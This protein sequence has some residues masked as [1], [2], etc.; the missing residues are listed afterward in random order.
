MSRSAQTGDNSLATTC[1]ARQPIV[2][3]AGRLAAYELLFR[4]G[5]S[6]VAN[7]SDGFRCTAEVVERTLGALGLTTVLDGLDGYLNCTADFLHSALPQM[8]PSQHF[9]LEV[10]ETCELD[11]ALK[12]RCIALRRAGFRVAIDDVVAI[13][14]QIEAFLPAVDIVKLE[15]PALDAA[16]AKA[17]VRDMKRAG[18]TVVAEKVDDHQQLQAALDAGCDLVQGFY[19]SRPQLL[20]ARR[21]VPDV[22]QL[23]AVLN[24]LI[25]DA[26]D[27]RIVNALSG[28]PVLVAQLMRLA[29]CSASANVKQAAIT[30]LHHALAVTG[31]TRLFEWCSLLLY[32][33]P[34]SGDLSRD[35][36]IAL[37]TQR[38]SFMMQAALRQRPSETAFAQT[39]S[40]TGMLSLL[41]VIYGREQAQFAQELPLAQN[42][43]DALADRR[44]ELGQLL[45][46]AEVFESRPEKNSASIEV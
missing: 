33:H 27:Q 37:A 36:V 20:R 17:M 34:D 12:E 13:T 18:K 11:D 14:P 6:G 44:G 43:R 38:A 5:D 24:L 42:I 10:L 30:S 16:A 19:F 29:N 28:M 3:R 21:I 32:N 2:D 8:L 39:A 40:L 26:P 22:S 45:G 31:T 35:P 46:A 9:V 23:L 4:D 15:W 41:H 1:V 25:N 7:I